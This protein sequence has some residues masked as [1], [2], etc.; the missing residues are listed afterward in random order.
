MKSIKWEKGS[1]IGA[2]IAA[3]TASLCCVAPFVLL[4]LG[5]SGAWIGALTEFDFL[6]PY[7]ITATVIF[8]ILAF[9]KLYVKPKRCTID[10]PCE[11]PKYLKIQRIIFWIVTILLIL[12]LSFPWY[13]FLFN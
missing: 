2:I 9:L 13:A 11:N 5:F 6:R 7:A 10:K 4:A 8:L 1:L 3:I 12:L